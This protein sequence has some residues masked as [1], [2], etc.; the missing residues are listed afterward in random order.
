MKAIRIHEFGGSE[1]LQIEEIENAIPGAGEILIKVAAAGIVSR[2]FAI[3]EDSAGW[4]TRSE[5]L[6]KWQIAA[7]TW[8]RQEGNFIAPSTA[9]SP[10]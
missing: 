10:A 8:R 1:R 9:L 4:P 3:A 2:A 7:G 6:P 5:M